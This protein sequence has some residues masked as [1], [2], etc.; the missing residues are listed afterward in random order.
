MP[1]V[2]EAEQVQF[3][4]LGKLGG[5]SNTYSKNSLGDPIFDVSG[6]LTFSTLFRFDMGVGIG[7]NFNWTMV[8]Q[9]MDE[10]KLTYALTAKERNTTFQLPSI[11]IAFRY[12]VAEIADFGLWLNYGFGSN[13]IDYKYANRETADLVKVAFNL[14]RANLEWELQSVEVGIMLAFMYKIEAAS[15]DLVFGIQGFLDVSRM[16]AADSSLNMAI[17]LHGRHLDENTAYTGGFH[18]VVGARYDL[19]FGNK[20]KK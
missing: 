11:G 6:G 13:A 19:M 1:T 18:I 7:L 3:E 20:K 9:W 15:L 17:D 5:T 4:L 12:E 16:R 10:T 14:N 2:A 8:E